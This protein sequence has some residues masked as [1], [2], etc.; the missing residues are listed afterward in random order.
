MKSRV[1]LND[2]VL[3]RVSFPSQAV[4]RTIA[5]SILACLACTQTASANT[6]FFDT[7][8]DGSAADGMP[9]TWVSQTGT[10]DASSSDYV[11]TGNG[12]RRSLIPAL[13]LADTSVRARVRLDGDPS[14]TIALGVGIRRATGPFGYAADIVSD[15]TIGLYRVDGTPTPNALATTVVPFETVGQDL[16]LQ[17]DAMGDELSMWVWP[18]GEPMPTDP[19]VAVAD[20]TYSSGSVGVLGLSFDATHDATFRFV[21]VADTHIPEPSS[22]LLAMVG[23]GSVLIVTRRLRNC[24]DSEKRRFFRVA[25]LALVFLVPLP[26]ISGA[27]EEK[28]SEEETLLATDRA[29]A[30]AAAAGDI[31]QILSMWTDDAVNY[32]PGRLPAVGKKAIRQLVLEN[33]ARPGFSLR[34][35]PTGASVARSNDIGYTHGSFEISV[36]SQDGTRESKRGYYVCICERQEDNSWKCAVEISNFCGDDQPTSD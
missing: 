15:G 11:S 7:F 21:H 4:V 3:G 33:R 20:S 22:C 12:I 25:L 9:V 24:G 2:V 18:V 27:E 32:F 8:N 16:L 26:K 35:E 10:W 23:V 14:Q 5:S 13:D 30:A 34:W 31:E 17:V 36:I 29:W 28:Q 6:I 19:Q 1:F